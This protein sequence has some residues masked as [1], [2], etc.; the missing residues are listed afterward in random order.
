MLLFLNCHFFA[1]LCVQSYIT[2]RRH[3]FR[4]YCADILNFTVTRDVTLW[5]VLVV[6]VA[7]SMD[8]LKRELSAFDD[9][10]TRMERSM[11][12]VSELM[13]F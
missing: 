11:Q 4:C 10:V 7:G 6:M 13:H 5:K 9:K 8:E 2:Q 12:Q 3:V 1:K